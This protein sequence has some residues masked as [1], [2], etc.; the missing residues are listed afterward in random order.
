MAD[1][2]AEAGSWAS[3]DVVEVLQANGVFLVPKFHLG[4]HTC[5]TKTKAIN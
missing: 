3:N 1:R 4:M 2:V 5:K